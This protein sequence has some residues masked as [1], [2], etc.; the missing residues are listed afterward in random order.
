MKSLLKRSLKKLL[1]VTGFVSGVAIAANNPGAPEID[2]RSYILM[3]FETGKVLLESNA[4]QALP[5][6]SLTK[7]MTGYIVSDELA[8]ANISN[9]DKVLVSENAWAQN[10]K[11]KGSSLMFI[12]VNKYVPM[13]DLHKG[14]VIQ[15]GNDAS[16]AVAEHISGTESAFANL[17]NQHAKRLGMSNTHFENSTGLPA[18]GHLTTARDLA[19][20]SRALIQ[21]FPE[22]YTIYAGREFT[23]NNITQQNRNTL[24]NDQGL[25]V[26][27]LKTGHTEEA[28]YCLV[29][30]AVNDEM[31]LIAVVMG[32]DSKAKRA[33]ES[34]KLLNHGFRFYTNV[35]PFEGGKSLKNARVWKGEVNE[36]PVGL[37]QDA[38]LTLLKADKEKLKANYTLNPEIIAPV[39]KG[40]I[41]GEVFFKIDGKEIKKMPMVAL[42][43]VPEAG[44]FGRMW[45]SIKLWF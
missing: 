24:L 38:T 21:D 26:D 22:D 16:I 27:G 14:I 35:T 41:V 20:L 17:M 5:P 11:L 36:F 28:G 31:R 18:D 4:D 40:Q 32:T 23:Y 44:F 10:P 25:K 29:S 45:D 15:S 6:A 13:D 1:I 39:K 43:D 34:R 2:A 42:A 8:K 9:D 37:A 33:S 12:E 7:I 19:I 30:S 3:D